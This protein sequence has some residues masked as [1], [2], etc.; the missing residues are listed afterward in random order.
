MLRDD[1]YRMS[2]WKEQRQES[3]L[4]LPPAP[5]PPPD[6]LGSVALQFHDTW[7]SMYVPLVF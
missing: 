4:P 2:R 7:N 6:N 5:E 1:R 3:E